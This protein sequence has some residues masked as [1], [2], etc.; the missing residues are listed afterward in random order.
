MTS[1]ISLF[2]LLL[3]FC[4]SAVLSA[5]DPINK[6]TNPPVEFVFSNKWQ[7]GHSVLLYYNA[8]MTTQ[9]DLRFNGGK[10]QPGR[11]DTEK[12]VL[13]AKLKLL[14][15]RNKQYPDDVF[16]ITIQSLNH[17]KNGISDDFS[18]I[19]NT[20]F[21]MIVRQNTISLLYEKTNW[22][23]PVIPAKTIHAAESI[24][25]EFFC[26]GNSSPEQVL[27]KNCAH[28]LGETWMLDTTWI[29]ELLKK[30][31][32]DTTPENW[33]AKATFTTTMDCLGIQANCIFVRIFN[34]PLPNYDCKIEANYYFPVKNSDN[35]GFIRLTKNIS[36]IVE[37]VMP[38][39][40]PMF[41][42]TMFTVTRKH[43]SDL[44]FLPLS[45]P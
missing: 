1:R 5:S 2:I 21:Q 20:P 13:S 8:E 43:V 44:S 30:R 33:I 22:M 14:A 35:H 27:G 6:D 25:A 39:D 7:V 12:L 24:L 9:Y 31:K 16:S 34:T 28:A 23:M 45:E 19:L 3:S 37:N 11:I 32:I 40:N 17:S 29:R 42:G 4:C 18:A 10:K 26:P 41:S 36:E 38:D 15:S